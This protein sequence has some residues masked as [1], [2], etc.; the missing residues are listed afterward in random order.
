MFAIYFGMDCLENFM[1]ES[2][3]ILGFAQKNEHASKYDFVHKALEHICKF[4]YYDT[5]CDEMSSN[6]IY[7]PASEYD[8][9]FIN[10]VLD[11]I[12]VD[13]MLGPF[14]NVYHIAKFE[15]HEKALLIETEDK[16]VFFWFSFSG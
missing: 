3:L 16:Y 15:G 7:E 1:G 2:E 13:L 14:K 12:A 6:L 4:G 9:E 10:M 5:Y 11:E 8:I